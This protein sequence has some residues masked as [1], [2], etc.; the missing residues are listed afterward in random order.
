MTVQPHDKIITSVKKH[1]RTKGMYAGPLLIHSDTD[2]SGAQNVISYM[3]HDAIK[4]A[5]LKAQVF[6]AVRESF[7]FR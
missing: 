1:D 3:L 7:Q 6:F 4:L 2:V 5:L